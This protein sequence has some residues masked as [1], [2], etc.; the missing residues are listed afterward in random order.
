[1]GKMVDARYY[2]ET[3]L[4]QTEAEA[5]IAAFTCVGDSTDCTGPDVLSVSYLPLS[6]PDFEYT[7]YTTGN[8]GQ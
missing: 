4:T 6:E 1:M 7:I 5:L 3:T 2:P 8:A